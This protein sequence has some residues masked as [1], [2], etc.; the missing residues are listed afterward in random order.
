MGGNL[1]CVIA[2]IDIDFFTHYY[3]DWIVNSRKFPV[4]FQIIVKI[5]SKCSAPLQPMHDR[6]K[7]VSQGTS[8][9]TQQNIVSLLLST[10]NV[11]VVRQNGVHTL[12]RE[13]LVDK[14]C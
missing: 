2:K 7:P 1:T 4:S 10:A 14:A 13:R 11:P 3:L 6:P 9:N 8:K 12:I 5:Y